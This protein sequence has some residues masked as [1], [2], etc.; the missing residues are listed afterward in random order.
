M[1]LTVSTL[2]SARV[3]LTSRT[4]PDEGR[5]TVMFTSVPGAPRNRFTASGRLSLSVLFP[6][7]LMMRS[8]V[9]IPAL[10]AGVSSIGATTVRKLSRTLITMPTP[11]NNPSV[12]FFSSLYFSASMNSLC[13]SSEFS[14]P[15]SAE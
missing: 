1:S 14:I 4:C 13:G 10:N 9:R 12:S 15:F 11:P 8:P 6:S 7:I 5:S 2:I 3:S